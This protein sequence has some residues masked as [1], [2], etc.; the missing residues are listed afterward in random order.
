ML[1]DCGA[2]GRIETLAKLRIPPRAHY[3]LRRHTSPL[4]VSRQ[5]TTARRMVFVS[6]VGVQRA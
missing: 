5:I 3:V 2:L 4:P 6:D 1:R